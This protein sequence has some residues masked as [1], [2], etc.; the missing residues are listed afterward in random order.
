MTV[1]ELLDKMDRLY[2][3]EEM[4]KRYG[5]DLEPGEAYTAEALDHMLALEPESGAGNLIVCN[6]YREWFPDEE[7]PEY[8]DTTLYKKTELLAENGR[9]HGYAYDMVSWP[10]ILGAD[11][12]D[13]SI[14]LYG[15]AECALAIYHEM[16]FFGCWRDQR[17]SNIRE[18]EEKISVEDCEL[19]EQV[20]P[21]SDLWEGLEV[22]EPELSCQ[23]EAQRIR[24]LQENRG[25]LEG[26]LERERQRL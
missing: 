8:M 13:T 23:E 24:V 16:T 15:E 22:P 6:Q 14:K 3:T 19:E 4:T 20:Y 25:I 9:G 7:S 11:V 2:I 12:A 5:S 17:E 18:L 10:Q 26:I 21:V 1:K